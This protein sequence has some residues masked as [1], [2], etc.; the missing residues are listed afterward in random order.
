[1]LAVAV[2]L[3]AD[4]GTVIMGLVCSVVSFAVQVTCAGFIYAK[5]EFIEPLADYTEGIE[6]VD[7]GVAEKASGSFEENA[8]GAACPSSR[9]CFRP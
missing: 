9:C 4:I 2:L 5:G 1:M 8:P 7:D 6:A 3:Q